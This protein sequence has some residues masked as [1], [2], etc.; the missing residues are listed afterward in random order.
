MSVPFLTPWMKQRDYF[1]SGRVYTCHIG[2]LVKIT[3]VACKG[4]IVDFIWA[5]V[6]FGDYVLDVVHQFAMLLRQQAVL[7]TILRPL[8]NKVARG[9]IHCFRFRWISSDAAS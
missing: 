5:P 3:A 6:L 7:T 2:P 8:A 1:S 4:K 9:G